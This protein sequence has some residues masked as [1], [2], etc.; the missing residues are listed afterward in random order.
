MV[1]HLPDSWSNWNLEMLVFEDTGKLENSAKN[2]LE[3]ESINDKLNPHMVP[4]GGGRGV[5]WEFLGGPELF[6]LNFATLY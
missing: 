4:V 1:L 2:P 3:Q 6:Q 5:L